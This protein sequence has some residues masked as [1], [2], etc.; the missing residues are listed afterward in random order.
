M[1][2]QPVTTAAPGDIYWRYTV[3]TRTDAKVWL[4]TKGNVAVTGNWHGE[5]GEF[6]KAWCP[7]P[8][9]NKELEKQLFGGLV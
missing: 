3:P 2:E 7:M 4:L 8:K 1:S 6:Y 5:I 9:R